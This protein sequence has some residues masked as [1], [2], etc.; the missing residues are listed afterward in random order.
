MLKKKFV[1]LATMVI[2]SLTCPTVFASEFSDVPNN[3]RAYSEIYKADNIGFMSGMDDHTFG[4]GQ[5]VTRAQFVSMLVRMFGW[6]KIS[7]SNSFNDVDNSKWYYADITTAVEHGVIK[8]DKTNFR[9]TDNITREEMAVMLI[10]ALGYDSLAEEAVKADTPFTDI[11]S[12]KG[13]INLA[14]DFGIVSGK[15]ATGFVPGGTALREE[16]AAMMIRCYDKYNSNI[17]FLHGFYA[18]SSY[19]QKELAASMDAVS[20][21]W[22]KMEYSDEKGVVLNTTSFNENEWC[23]PSGYEDIASYLKNNNVKTNLNVFLSDSESLAGSAIL[24]SAQNRKQAVKAIIDELSVSY[25]Q[26]G[27]NPY[28]GVTIDFENLR[29][30]ELKNSFVLFLKEL[31]EELNSL[32]KTLYVT[33]QPNMKSG[34]YFDGYDFKEIGGV[35]DKIILMA[36]DYQAKK[37]PQSVM[38]SGF[39]TTPVTPF[40]EVY[41]ALKTITDSKTGVQDKSKIVLGMSMSNV[42]WNVADGKITNAKGLTYSYSELLNHIETNGNVMYSDKYKNSYLTF[43]SDAGTTT[44]WYEDSRSIYDKIKLAEMFGIKSVSI[45]RLGTI[46]DYSSS[47][48]LNIWSCINDLK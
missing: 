19:S 40:D 42:G 18:F 29:G 13:Y 47:S 25:K 36:Y 16:A 3:H 23:V 41:Y 48:N 6:E 38:E 9:P 28:S 14:Y 44:V 8:A 2:S 12:N 4:L 32:N 37:I 43:E 11:V 33:V 7:G 39:T 20:F 45:W 35:A 1:L 31:K 26:L 17:D 34:E 21:G 22:G 46:P 10:R 27:Y 15:S 30:T 24:N 5:N